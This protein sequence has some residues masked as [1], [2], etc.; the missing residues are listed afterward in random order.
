MGKKGFKLD[1]VKKKNH[2]VNSDSE[3]DQISDD[4]VSEVENKILS[5]EQA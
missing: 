2:N 1:S 4:S 5:K 3:D